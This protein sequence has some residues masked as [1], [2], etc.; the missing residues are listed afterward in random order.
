MKF[1]IVSEEESYDSALEYA[2][3]EGMDG[4]LGFHFRDGGEYS[5]GR[6]FAGIEMRHPEFPEADPRELDVDTVD[7]VD[8]ND[9]T[10]AGMRASGFYENCDDV[11]TYFNNFDDA[12]ELM[13]SNGGDKNFFQF[14]HVLDGRAKKNGEL[15]LQV[16]EDSDFYDS[17]FYNTML[18]LADKQ[19]PFFQDS[20]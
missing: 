18:T 13:E 15:V 7:A 9:L 6:N 12:A 5:P 11:L 10:G 19:D 20:L 1:H 2:D 17:Q 16:D 8:Y 14:L 4:V 3:Q